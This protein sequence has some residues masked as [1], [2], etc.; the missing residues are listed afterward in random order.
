MKEKR[1]K[2]DRGQFNNED[3]TWSVRDKENSVEVK[4]VIFSVKY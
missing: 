4:K 1:N 3:S 2:M